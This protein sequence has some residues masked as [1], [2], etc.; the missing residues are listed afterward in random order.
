V[1]RTGTDA[2]A[3]ENAD[4][5]AAAREFTPNRAAD[6]PGANDDDLLGSFHVPMILRPADNRATGRHRFWVVT[7]T[8]QCL[9]FAAAV[10]PGWF[11]TC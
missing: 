2:A 4:A 8:R 6:D 9:E 5:G 10:R 1:S 11:N 7:S 3:F